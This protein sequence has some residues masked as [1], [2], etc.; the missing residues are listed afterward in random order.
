MKQATRLTSWEQ[1]KRLADPRRLA[2]L[3]L[4]MARPATLTQLARQVGHSP[5]WVRHH[6]Q[7][8]QRAGLVEPVHPDAGGRG[9]ATL[10]R[11]TAGA[12][13]LQRLVLPASDRPTLVFAGS[14]DLALERLAEDLAPYLDLILHPVGSLDGLVSLRQGLCHL[15]GAHLLDETG[16]YN[17]PYVRHLFPDRRVRVITLAH[18]VQGLMTAPGNPLGLRDLSD[19]ARPG[20]RFVNRNPGSGTRLWLDARLRALGIPPE[21]IQ[22][23][24]WEVATHTAAARAVAEGRADVALGLE[25]AAL[26]QGLGFIPLFEERFDLIFPTEETAELTPLLDT[27]QT[28]AFRRL[29]RTLHGYNPA[30][31][32]EEIEITLP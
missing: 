21:A 6:I 31:A 7:Q 32:G 23:Y 1:I 14:H 29:M 27:L 24:A 4:L 15:S 8:L 3:R 22:G 12:W 26:R 18:R 19:L 28:A 5:A 16:A 20:V 30:H 10:Y 2:L 17:T 25:A 9:R 13:I 11:A